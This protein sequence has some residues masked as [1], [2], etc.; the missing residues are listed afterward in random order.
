MNT[1]TAP[2]IYEVPEQVYHFPAVTVILP[3]NPKMD[4]KR[5]LSNSL[6]MA[7][8]KVEHDLYENFPDEI[9]ALVMQK[10]ESVFS[11]LDFRTHTISVAI[12]LSPVFEKVL[13][14]DFPVDETITVNESFEIRDLVYSKKELHEY[15]V[16]L[17]SNKE[18]RMYIGTPGVFKKI[19]SNTPGS[20]YVRQANVRDKAG[21]ELLNQ[22][23]IIKDNFLR[24]NDNVLD[25]ILKAYPLP[26]F[27]LGKETITKQ[28]K[29]LTK[30]SSA[31]IKYLE[32]NY[33]TSNSEQLMEIMYPH[34]VDWRKVKQKQILNQL[35][36]AACKKQLTTGLNNVWLEAIN[37]KGHLLVVEK[38]YVYNSYVI[39]A[40]N[41]SID[42]LI[43]KA[44]KP[45]NNFSCV[46][47]QLDEAIE[48]VLE[49]GGDVEFVDKEVLGCYDHIALI[50]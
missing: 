33:E 24:Y 3:F 11:N 47:N 49:N 44:I 5:A 4:S 7:V 6:S 39:N 25:I 35:E 31:A 43:H 38:N 18:C 40:K 17:L 27:V 36:A 2:K 1:L 45:Y 29:S 8:R 50:K 42:N 13:Y 22:E 15:I 10:L 30:H 12:Y 48:K 20:A 32:G 37:R 19:L 16:L 26:L 46:K 23:D 28:F 9:S 14:L 41:K 21:P 34:I